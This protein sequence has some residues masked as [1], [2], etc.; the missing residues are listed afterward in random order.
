MKGS[1]GEIRGTL[2]TPSFHLTKADLNSLRE[3]LCL[4]CMTQSISVCVILPFPVEHR[5][6][7]EH[8]RSKHQTP[9][10]QARIIVFT[11]L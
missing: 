4:K 5:E 8:V 2:H 9:E 10:Q 11:L 1:M 3:G 6:H 7:R